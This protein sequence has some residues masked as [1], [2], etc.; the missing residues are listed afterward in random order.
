[1][2]IR[3]STGMETACR[4]RVYPI[5]KVQSVYP[6]LAASPA[7]TTAVPIKGA[8][9]DPADLRSHCTSRERAMRED[10]RVD[11]DTNSDDDCF[12]DVSDRVA[13]RR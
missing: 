6:L 7:Q 11:D 12:G 5:K 10:E 4:Q 8:P 2:K 9:R 13:G 3:L 1:M